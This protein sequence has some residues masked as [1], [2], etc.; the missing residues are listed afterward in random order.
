MVHNGT[1]WKGYQGVYASADALR[2]NCF[3]ATEPTT[4]QD[5]SSALVTGDI[6]VSDSRLRK[7]S[8]STQI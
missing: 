3:S 1:T 4:Q 7:L 5:G 6:W 2:T 8:T